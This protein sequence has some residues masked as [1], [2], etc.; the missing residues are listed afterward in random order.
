MDRPIE[1][2]EIR[3]QTLRRIA[4]WGLALVALVALALA[5]RAWVR[6]SLKASRLR[7]AT[8]ERGR[9]EAAT[10]TSGT[11]V[12]AMEQ[13]ISCPFDTRVQEVL[14][15]PGAALR[16]VQ[17]LVQLDDTDARL[18]VEEI[19]DQIALKQNR[20][21]QLSYD[22]E[23][24]LNRLYGEQE[25]K[26]GRLAFLE[27]KTEQHR[28]LREAG[29]KSAFE[30]RQVELDEKIARI[31][32]RQLAESVE[33]ER[34]STETQVE[35]LEIET[36]LLRK[37]LREQQDRLARATVRADRNGVLTWITP[38]EGAA[39]RQGEVVARIADLSRFRVEASVSDLH[40]NRIAIGMPVRVVVNDQTLTGRVSNIPPA[41]DKGIM[42][43]HVE[44]DAPDSALLRLNMR[45]D[46]HVIT[47]LRPDALRVAKGPFVNGPGRQQVFVVRGEEA[48]RTA[49]RIGAAGI[50]HYEILSGLAEGERVI[51]SN[52]TDYL[53][54]ERIRI[55]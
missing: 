49:V 10:L 8:V 4:G 2:R 16:P 45:V 50:D 51:I 53:H 13:V 46:V 15:Q 1:E 3:K 6:P 44:L 37:N 29:L 40:A 21:R 22:L 28:A 25:I 23:R 9:V 7:S 47:E 30:L 12:P 24:R 52:M 38:E 27:A 32:L 34:R 43:L 26:E 18:R 42:T 14:E 35:G 19:E 48:V 54:L 55:R 31:E 5:A 36:S 39:L 33:E 11:V 41:I 17:P 20:R